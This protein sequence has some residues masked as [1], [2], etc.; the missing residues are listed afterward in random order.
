MLGFKR[1]PTQASK[2]A[3]AEP[4]WLRRYVVPGAA[5]ATL[6]AGVGAGYHAWHD[7]T[8]LPVKTVRV[9][10]RLEYIDAEQ[11]RRAVAAATHGNLI[12]VDVDAIRDAV[13]ALPWVYSVSVH[14]VWPDTLALAVVEQQAV[15]A[16]S[17]GGYVN[18][19]GEVFDAGLRHVS[20]ALPV[21]DGPADT[22]A[23]MTRT[24][25]DT[26]AALAGT[27]LHIARLGLSDRRA[28]R[29]TLDN[30]IE[31]EVGRRDR[32]SRLSRFARVYRAT[33]STMAKDIR[34]VDLRYTNGFAVRWKDH[35]QAWT[36]AIAPVARVV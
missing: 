30:G 25:Y 6:V 17:H 23:V 20:A 2:Q 22:A 27:G 9:S 26:G 31:L 19:A 7:T 11:L 15:A 33:L 1:D 28:W 10:G 12:S 29:V 16:W 3:G 32:L 34:Q 14:R 21:F 35:G 24:Y 18:A 13:K 36:D 4:G 5:M 8:L